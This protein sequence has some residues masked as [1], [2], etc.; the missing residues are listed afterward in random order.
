ME[1]IQMDFPTSA[2][3]FFLSP[4]GKIHYRQLEGDSESTIVILPGFTMPSALY[5]G[6]AQSLHADGHSVIVVDYWGRGFSEARNDKNYSLDSHIWLVF[7]LL[8]HLQIQRSSFIGVSYGAA[9]LAGVAARHPEIVDKLVFISPLHFTNET[10]T[11][12]QK[13]VLGTPSLGPIILRMTA[14]KMVPQQISK[15][16]SNPKE[17]KE[18]VQAVSRI[19]MQE[20]HQSWAKVDAISKAIAAFEVADVEQAFA[21]VANVN[22]RMLVLI[23]ENDALVNLGECKAWWARWIQNANLQV[24]EGAGHLLFIEKSK[25]VAAGLRTFFSQ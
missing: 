23:G 9:V 22:K 13:V 8:R 7:S 10:P 24:I 16:F 20:Y 14:L 11:A 4:H 18:L 21:G 1:E 3:F 5:W 25:E 17:N 12:L 2:Q 19:C 15:Q 6:L